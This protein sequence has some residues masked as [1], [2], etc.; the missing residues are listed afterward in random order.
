[1]KVIKRFLMIGWYFLIKIG[2]L[3]VYENHGRKRSSTSLGLSGPMKQQWLP[4]QDC[5]SGL[6]N[7]VNLS[8]IHQVAKTSRVET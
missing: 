7:L 4:R 8:Y 2:V 6:A 1:M 3:W 5:K